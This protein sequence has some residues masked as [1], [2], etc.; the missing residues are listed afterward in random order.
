VS[1][2]PE[3]DA[4]VVG[5]GPNGLAAAIEIARTGRRVVVFEAAETVGGGCRSA[6][7]TLPGFVHDVCS[8]VHPFAV[9]S[10]AFRALPLAA[11]GVEWV[12]PPVM[13]AH[14]LENGRAACAYRSLPQTVAALGEDGPGYRALVEPV[15]DSWPSI[16][17]SVLGPLAWPD[18]P[19][20]LARFG[21][22]A[23]R[24]ASS[25]ARRIFPGGAG[26]A[27]LA[28]V[29][30]HSMLPLETA[31]TAGVALALMGMAHYA[32]WSMPRG[33]AQRLS[34]ALADHLRALGG[35]IVTGR[36]I[37]TLDELPAAR[38]V[39][40]D[41]SPRPLLS[42]AGHRLPPRFRR[43]LERYRYGMGVFKVD[44]A[45]DGPI[46]WSNTECR[47]A[48]TLHVGGTLEEIA[49]AE[50][51]TWEGRVP[52]RPYVLVTQPTLFDPSR[53]PAGRHVA[54]MYCHVPHGAD[55]D[56]LPRLERQI[57]RYA[58]GFRE[59]VLA[60]SVM[61]P[62]DMERQNPNFV[63]GDIASGA[64]TLRQ[65]FTRPTWRTYSTPV[66]GLYLCSAAT[67]PGVGVHGMCGYF[68]ARRALQE[69]LRE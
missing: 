31:P 42:L 3:F 45:L 32:G 49:A 51:E 14:P 30:A 61:R 60:R 39:L 53:A 25:L 36:R 48:G 43:A 5:S 10:P 56:M 11:L 16:E 63:G 59:R 9:T 44:Y 17:R 15:L 67:P 13:Y 40:C 1:R 7:L 33:G 38:A 50:R 46:P 22:R 27:L 28:G 54:W 47:R 65:L 57:E 68:A 37:V 29:A 41:L 58:P 8:A 66:R 20:A 35:L 52:D 34:D 19:L 55:V 4:V 62:A 69:V 18:H 23:L 6:A 26:R 12:E 24:P 21:T 64:P 2:R